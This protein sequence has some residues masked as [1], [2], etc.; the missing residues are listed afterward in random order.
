[1]PGWDTPQSA[2]QSNSNSNSNTGR[3]TGSNY[4]QFDRAVSQAQNNPAPSS[5]GDGVNWS[6]SD[7]IDSTYTTTSFD[8]TPEESSAGEFMN[9]ITSAYEKVEVPIKAL[10]VVTSADPFS[11]GLNMLSYVAA[12]NK[13]KAAQQAYI[14]TLP[15]GEDGYGE[16][17]YM[18]D[19]QDY[20][21]RVYDTDYSGLDQEGQAELDL[22]YAKN[23]GLDYF[24]PN[25]IIKDGNINLEDINKLPNEQQEI[26]TDLVP[27]MAS[28]VGGSE[29]PPSVFDKFFSNIA[30]SGNHI[31][32]R[33][34]TAKAKTNNF[35]TTPITTASYGI[36]EDA[37]LKGLI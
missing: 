11:F 12:K 8:V 4:G 24:D 14:D 19:V 20:S 5:G 31:L 18:E 13:Q 15:T 29:L 1:M 16:G 32:E 35:I 9:N 6:P 2:G 10:N 33:Y 21:A 37:R 3:D 22:D 7:D 30:Q 23:Y 25:E 28:V 17:D 26:I 27:Y 34:N 36:F